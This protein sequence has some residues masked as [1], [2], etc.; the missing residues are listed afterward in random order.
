MADSYKSEWKW[1]VWIPD[2][3]KKAPSSVILT[4]EQQCT[5]TTLVTAEWPHISHNTTQAVCHQD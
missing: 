4:T 3:Q 1:K 5:V 2:R